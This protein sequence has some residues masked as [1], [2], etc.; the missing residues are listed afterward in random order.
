M[1][2]SHPLLSSR[3]ALCLLFIPALT[4][5]AHAQGEPEADPAGS[6]ELQTSYWAH[7]GPAARFARPEAL[8]M[9]ALGADVRFLDLNVPPEGDMPR[10]VAFTPDGLS[11][12]VANRDTD[13][14]TFLDFASQQVTDTVAVG[15]FPVSVKVTADGNLA[16]CTN[17]FSDSVS[18]VDVATRSLLAEVPVTGT[19]P[20][21]VELTPDSQFAVV[22]V[23]N[24]AVTSA[25]A[26]ID[27][28]SFSEIANFPTTP[29]G[30]VGFY[31]TPEFAIG[32]N[33][34][35][36]W[37]LS[38]DGNT[39][40]LPDRAGSQV[41]LYDR[42]S[43]MQ[44]AALATAGSPA[45]ADISLDSTMA[46]VSHEGSAQALTV[47]DLTSQS[48]TAT[49]AVGV[50]LWSQVVRITPD[51]SHA[52][53]A[54]MN[55]VVFIN[56]SSGAVTATLSTGTVGD[57][58]LTADQQSFIVSNY[59]TRKIN[60]ATQ[61][62]TAQMTLAACVE[63]AVSPV[64]ARAVALNNRFREDVQF[65]DT[66][67]TAS[68]LGRVSSGAQPEADV[69]RA[70]AVSADGS[71]AVVGHALS[72]S[73]SIVDLATESVRATLP[74]GE[75][76]LDVEITPDGNYAVVVGT[77][78]HKVTIIDLATDSVVADLTVGSRP[79]KVRISADSQTA[80]VTSVAGTDRLW[81]INLAGAASAITGSV[82]T[83]QMGSAGGYSFSE[84]S[85]LELSPDGAVLAVCVSFDDNLLLVDAATQA[86]LAQLPVG[87][88]PIRAAFSADSTRCYVIDYFSDSIFAVD[89]AG[90]A[91]SVAGSLGNIPLPATVDVD[92][93]GNFVYVGSY[94]SAA[95]GL[96]IVDAGTLTLVNVLPIGRVRESR[97][98][99]AEGL[100]YLVVDGPSS[101]YELVRVQLNGA[102]S[103][104]LDSF[105]LDAQGIGL[106]VSVALGK[107]VVS[108]PAMEAVNIIGSSPWSTY[109]T[110]A[111]NS[112]GFGA[113]IS[114][115]G[116]A[117]QAANDLV[118]EIS[119][120]IPSNVGL[121]YYGPNQIE[122]PFGHGFRCVGGTSFRLHPA[123]V[124]DASGQTQRAIDNTLPP[125][126]SGPGALM[127]GSTFQFQYWYRDPAAGGANFNLSNALSVTFAP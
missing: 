85:G 10:A 82:V 63:L 65:Y 66:S 47:I 116:S 111:P 78:S 103:S 117:S 71:T 123:Q 48:I 11:V 27:L 99:P 54:I 35:S 46:V 20:F 37:A 62:V 60:I 68:A 64:S 127:P 29:Q 14:L 55:N 9:A 17:L 81:F 42:A 50:N 94:F 90:A 6:S 122:V 23:I 114:A 92:P 105:P 107:A 33:I 98:S 124:A 4:A 32:S 89:I 49:H 16:V 39:I 96:H 22:S 76:I 86:V 83:G 45:A 41:L 18:I 53:A 118:L 43:G 70:V 97:L 84:F 72:R 7:P 3:T 59:T 101:T 93:N 8:G 31:F 113:Q 40:V 34:F 110:A 115:S 125:A 28:T 108:L 13:N 67:A 58:Q 5:L 88:F 69:P 95:G 73:A 87:D 56:L 51:K 79:S 30:V 38:P 100:L 91:S 126:N 19:Q 36:E 80:Y 52:L 102:A 25:F 21:G 12:V 15:D 109:C 26:V 119:G 61:S 24:D 1:L 57:I 121:F 106:D 2:D 120:A 44:L 74:A 104:V 75:R 77:D 112:A